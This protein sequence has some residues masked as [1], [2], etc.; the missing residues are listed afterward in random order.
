MKA[1]LTYHSVDDSGSVISV[2]PSQLEQ[3]LDTL[4]SKSVRIVPLTSLSAVPWDV[5]AVS[6][7]FDDGFANFASAAAPVLVSRT[8]PATVFVL[9][10]HVGASNDWEAKDSRFPVPHLRLMGWADIAQVRLQGFDIGGH[11]MTHRS[12][13]SLD[14][15]Q[16]SREVRDC[17]AL[18]EERVGA[19]P[20][21]FA[22]PY[23]DYDDA[24]VAAVAETYPI[25]CTTR[26]DTLSATDSLHALPRLDMYYFR[27]GKMLARW[28]SPEFKAYIA[29]RKFA[30]SIG[31][32]LRK[33]M[34]TDNG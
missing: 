22:F 26:F 20:S 9:P 8:A 14:S 1:I 11:G 10:S 32:V 13:K 18:I 27:G 25:A 29:G 12:L 15:E 17:A 24:A 2:T 34:R 3:H 33:R 30:R 19:A 16:L 5:D 21:A 4:H 31:T 23:G 6:L 7:T 28:G